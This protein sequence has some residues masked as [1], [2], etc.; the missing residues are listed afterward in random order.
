MKIFFTASLHGKSKYNEHYRLIDEGV[1]AKGHTIKSD[2]ILNYSI[3]SS[4][5]WDEQKNLQYHREVMDG[6]KQADALFVEASY[7]S[8]S[9]G[10]LICFAVQMGK[11]VIIFHSGVEE[12]HMFR[13]LEKLNEKLQ[14]V[15]YA[16]LEELKSEVP[17]A[18]EFVADSQD[19]RFNF[20]ISPDHSQYLDWIA[21]NRKISRSVYLR[22]LIEQ[23]M[24]EG[25]E[26]PQI[27]N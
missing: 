2:H 14:V 18:L 8:T 5:G 26:D 27:T 17:H 13:T 19:T 16:S 1:K 15:R 21:K 9:V 23:D 20:F 22:T 11:P 10:Y 12:P 4:G 6:I 3:E 25:G 7:A 24:R